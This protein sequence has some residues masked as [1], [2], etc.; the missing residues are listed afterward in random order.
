ASDYGNCFLDAALQGHWIGSGSYGL[1]AFAVDRLRQH[2]RG[3]G[4][5]ASDIRGFRSNF[6]DH[7]CAH[8]FQAVFEFDFFCA[9][10]AVLGDGPGTVF[11]FDNYVAGFGA[12]R[13]FYSIS[14]QVDAAE[15]RLARL[16]SVNNLLCHTFL[17]MLFAGLACDFY[18]NRA[19][20]SVLSSRFA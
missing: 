1:Y 16:F 10:H 4:A 15:D 11:L 14:Q 12:E 8:V 20:T 2:G 7:L 9:R 19:G 3:G 6:A 5:V 18:L 13:D 17:L